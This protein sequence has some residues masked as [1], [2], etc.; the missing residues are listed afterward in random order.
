MA[1]DS[2]AIEEL[3]S[4]RGLGEI[5]SL[6]TPFYLTESG[7]YTAEELRAYFHLSGLTVNPAPE[8]PEEELS[9]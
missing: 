7:V 2:G 3:L 5:V 8:E 9:W 6:E 4:S 1:E